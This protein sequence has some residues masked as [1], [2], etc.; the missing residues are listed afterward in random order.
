MA[1]SNKRVLWNLSSMKHPSTIRKFGVETHSFLF[2][3]SCTLRL[4][5]RGDHFGSCYHYSSSTIQK[6]TRN[7][8][9][10]MAAK[11][12]AVDHASS[13]ESLLPNIKIPS[14]V[15][16]QMKHNEIQFYQLMKKNHY[17]EFSN[18]WKGCLVVGSLFGTLM[19]YYFLKTPS[20]MIT[21]G[22][23]LGFYLNQVLQEKEQ[24]NPIVI[25]NIMKWLK[26]NNRD[27]IHMMVQ[28][29][30]LDTLLDILMKTMEKYNNRN[31]EMNEMEN[32]SNMLHEV[33]SIMYLV[34]KC[35]HNLREINSAHLNSEQRK[36]IERAVTALLSNG[37][38]TPTN[39][40]VRNE[41]TI[42]NIVNDEKRWL[43]STTHTNTLSSLLKIAYELS[44][45]ISKNDLEKTLQ[46]LQERSNFFQ[47]VKDHFE[48]RVS[49]VLQ[50]IE[51]GI[52]PSQEEKEYMQKIENRFENP[53]EHAESFFLSAL[54]LKLINDRVISLDEMKSS[55]SLMNFLRSEFYGNGHLSFIPCG[56]IL[57][58]MGDISRNSPLRTRLLYPVVDEIE[59]NV[60]I[61]QLRTTLILAQHDYSCLDKK[62]FR[63]ELSSLRPQVKGTYLEPFL[64]YIISSQFGYVGEVELLQQESLLYSAV[65]HESGCGIRDVNLMF[66]LGNLLLKRQDLAKGFEIF[67]KIQQSFPFYAPIKGVLGG[68]CMPQ[69]IKLMLN[70]Q[71]IANHVLSLDKWDVCYKLRLEVQ[72]QSMK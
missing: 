41:D 69:N 24:V 15:Q 45:P 18:I 20:S 37:F 35:D 26:L 23:S 62:N 67:S 54:L 63:D 13:S 60:N 71:H 22:E 43:L 4:P 65:N 33:L 39:L 28:S 36:K 27:G 30:A 61:N 56:A 7:E 58:M 10:S 57:L 44:L 8:E 55:Q 31:Q 66:E 3:K 32:S 16:E 52:E 50:N 34:V 46:L 40:L 1:S 9:L 49:K 11:T 72:K 14:N 25:Q 38:I 29:G 12:S 17:R 5:L 48:Q 68:F 70:S 51:R 19:L 64:E 21:G 42:E 53:H 6:K 2:N 47:R 59:N